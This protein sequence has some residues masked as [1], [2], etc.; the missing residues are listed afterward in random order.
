VILVEVDEDQHKHYGV[1]C[2]VARMLDIIAEH[3]KTGRKEKR[4][5]VRYNP[6][7]FMVDF[8]R[9]KVLQK[10]RFAQLLEAIRQEPGQQFEIKYLFYDQSSPFPEVCLGPDYPRELR[11]LVR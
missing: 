6:D 8:K 9:A 3:M 2:D 10:D 7:A 5:L 1:L 11:D 4:K